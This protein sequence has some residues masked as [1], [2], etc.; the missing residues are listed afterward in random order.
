MAL[1]SCWSLCPPET[2]CSLGTPPS[3]L[4]EIPKP[5]LAAP[6]L[7]LFT[8][9]WRRLQHYTGSFSLVFRSA[10]I[11][12]VKGMLKKGAFCSTHTALML[13]GE[14]GRGYYDQ[15][16]VKMVGTGNK[17]KSY[18]VGIESESG[19]DSLLFHLCNLFVL[20]SYKKKCYSHFHHKA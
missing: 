17:K 10:S 6:A 18:W 7:L 19:Y 4:Q 2:S 9:I 12:G 8:G 20:F 14:E 11:P 5:Q 3:K 16:G 13:S 1:C 15:E